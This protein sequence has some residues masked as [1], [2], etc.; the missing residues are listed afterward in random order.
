[1]VAASNH[2]RY[3]R[4][5]PWEPFLARKTERDRVPP[6]TSFSVSVSVVLTTLHRSTGV[7]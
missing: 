4:L 6:Q 5:S 1:M 2:H 7:F 3:R